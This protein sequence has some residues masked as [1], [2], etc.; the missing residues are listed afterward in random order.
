MDSNERVEAIRRM[1]A[2]ERQRPLSAGRL[3]S[4][5]DMDALLA[6]LAHAEQELYGTKQARGLREEV[7]ALRAEVERLNQALADL[8][9]ESVSA[10]HVDKLEAALARTQA[11]LLKAADR[12]HGLCESHPGEHPLHSFAECPAYECVEARAALEGRG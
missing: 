3:W 11:A 12:H 8:A 1:R 10:D 9:N 2:D 6:A 4:G 7:L 5:D